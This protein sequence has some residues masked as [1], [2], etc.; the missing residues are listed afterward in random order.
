MF[1]AILKGA[2]SHLYRQARRLG[3]GTNAMIGNRRA[4]HQLHQLDDRTL[5]D[6]GIVRGSLTQNELWSSRWDSQLV[7]PYDAR[8]RLKE[9]ELQEAVRLDIQASD[10]I[11]SERQKENRSLKAS[12]ISLKPCGAESS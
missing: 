7:D 8:R 4:L 10:P 11:A 6:I 5:A 1:L 2:F 12:R 3:A 9:I